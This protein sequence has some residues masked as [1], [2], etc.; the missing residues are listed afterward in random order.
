MALF[1]I[2]AKNLQLEFTILQVFLVVVE[3]KAVQVKKQ[4]PN[5]NNDL[6]QL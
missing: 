5:V 1:S 2:A 6:M 4:K 3:L